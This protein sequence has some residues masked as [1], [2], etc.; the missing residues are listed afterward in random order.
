MNKSHHAKSL[1]LLCACL[2]TVLAA[3]A[4]CALLGCSRKPAP[5][6]KPALRLDV[7]VLPVTPLEVHS[8]ITNISDKPVTVPTNSY[9]GGSDG[10][11]T[12]GEYIAMF[13]TIG[14][15]KLGKY[16]LVPSPSRHF[17]V[18]LEPGE[19]AEL[20]VMHPRRHAEKSI[21]VYYTVDEDYAAR[22]GWWSGTLKKEVTIGEDNGE[23]PYI[24]TVLLPLDTLDIPDDKPE[25][26]KTQGLP[27]EPPQQT[28]SPANK[29]P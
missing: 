6:E 24:C 21:K 19:S 22:F 18:T 12:G 5:Q 2:P 14:F 4:L 29:R 1:F 9:S 15:G 7:F 16:K 27:P 20:P 17:P 3:L 28:D 23:N 26:Q 10:W 13:F 11:V 8:I 25:Q